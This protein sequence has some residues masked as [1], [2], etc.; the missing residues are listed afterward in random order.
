[1]GKD[2]RLY[3]I[4]APGFSLHTRA[5]AVLDEEGAEL[6]LECLQTLRR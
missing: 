6:E 1:M 2:G 3:I 4:R 5:G